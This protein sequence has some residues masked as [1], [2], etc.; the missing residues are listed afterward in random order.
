MNLP[1][2]DAS[3]KFRCALAVILVLLAFAGNANAIDA[4]A[5]KAQIDKARTFVA[6]LLE[7]TADAESGSYDPDVERDVLTSIRSALP[8]T[9]TVEWQGQAIEVSNGA[10]YARLKSFEDEESST[11][12][13]IYLTEADELMSA[14]ST[15]LAAPGAADEHSKDENKRK[16]AEILARGEYQKPAPKQ[17]SGITGLIERFISWLRSLFPDSGPAETLPY[18]FSGVAKVLQVLLFAIIFG[19]VGFLL[20]KFAPLLFPAARRGSRV[21]K[22]HRTI[23]G[24]KI[25]ADASSSDLFSDAER[26]ARDGEIRAAI[27][28]GYIALL[29]DLSDKNVIALEQHKT[30]RDYLRSVRARPTLYGNMRG[31]TSSFERHWYGSQPTAADDWDTFRETYKKAV[32]DA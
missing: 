4:A 6:Q 29:C 15:Q 16:L 14:L 11:K 25:A 8:E 21:R 32:A 2:A 23:L 30:N 7:Y 5:Y 20:Y 9:E 13:A 1:N 3:P 10:I 28:K 27:R 24:E 26:L 18:D 12:R 31:L 17:E 19:L 22:S